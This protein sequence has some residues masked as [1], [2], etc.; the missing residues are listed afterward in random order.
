MSFGVFG[1]HPV[2]CRFIALRTHS[3]HDF[4]AVVRMK[5]RRI[6]R[7]GRR[8]VLQ[9]LQLLHTLLRV[10][11][12]LFTDDGAAFIAW[13]ANHLAIANMR[14]HLDC[15]GRLSEL[16][17]RAVFISARRAR[18]PIPLQMQ[19]RFRVS[20]YAREER[21]RDKVVRLAR[22]RWTKSRDVKW[23]ANVDTMG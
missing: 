13:T 4:N 21:R 8:R 11:T 22:V 6:E 2:V 14:Y 10:G 9:G 15:S 3:H 23:L 17:E 5:K 18:T 7:R 12:A 1:T 16:I 20:K 19:A